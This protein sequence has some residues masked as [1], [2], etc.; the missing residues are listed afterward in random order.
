MCTNERL[1]RGF[2]LV[3]LLVVITI[4]GILIA[5]LLPA[6]Q[7]AREAA[8]RMQCSNNLR[9]LALGMLQHEQA[10]GKFPSGGWDYRWLPDAN[11]G[12]GWRQ[13]GSWVYSILPYIDQ[14]QLFQLGLGLSGTALSN[15]QVQMAQTP[16]AVMNCPTRRPSR[17]FDRSCTGYKTVPNG[18]T[19]LTIPL[20]ARGDY[21]ASYGDMQYAEGYVLNTGGVDSYAAADAWTANPKLSG[22]NADTKPTVWPQHIQSACTP[23]VLFT[24]IVYQKSE[25]T[26]AMIQDGLSC[27]YLCGEKYL[28]PDHYTDG[29]DLG[30]TETFYNGDDDDNQR[31]SW[32]PPKED[33]PGWAPGT[34]AGIGLWGSAHDGGINMAFCDG[35][36]HQISYLI[37][38]WPSVTHSPG[39]GQ[40]ND[41]PGVHQKLGN[42]ADG[43]QV[44]PAQF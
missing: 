41:I 11:R 27:T 21:A 44:D 38:S 16:L 24:G 26:A 32:D 14:M 40:P 9:N 37:D 1:Q 22:W 25:V 35:S 12:F 18:N 31:T 3:E 33:T 23:T 29:L 34:Y 39:S 17:L 6:V 28:N 19:T 10:N 15:A 36:V 30:D 8:R 42:R 5:L 2:T 7:A 13:P 20:C 4:I 43:M